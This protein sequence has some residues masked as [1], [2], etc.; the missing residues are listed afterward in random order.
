[1]IRA[2]LFGWFANFGKSLPLFNGHPNWFI[3]TNGKHTMSMSAYHLS[4][5]FGNSGENLNGTVRPGGKFSEK[6]AISFE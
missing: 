2:I 4:G 3:M 5:I 1:M 6:K